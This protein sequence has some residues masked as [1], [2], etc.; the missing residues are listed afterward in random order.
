MGKW[1]GESLIVLK[2]R[3]DWKSEDKRG[4]NSGPDEWENEL[5]QGNTV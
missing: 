4:S 5:N 3:M 1:S 2:E